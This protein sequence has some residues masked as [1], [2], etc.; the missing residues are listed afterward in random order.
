M[1]PRRS[2]V[3]CSLKHPVTYALAASL[4]AKWLYEAPYATNCQYIPLKTFRRGLFIHTKPYH[5]APSVT[6]YTSPLCVYQIYKIKEWSQVIK[7]YLLDGQVNRKVRVAAVI[8]EQLLLWEDQ[9]LPL[10]MIATLDRSNVSVTFLI[11]GFL[12]ECNCWCSSICLCNPKSRIPWSGT[13][14]QKT[15]LLPRIATTIQ[16]W[17]CS[18]IPLLVP[19]WALHLPCLLPSFWTLGPYASARLSLSS[20]KRRNPAKTEMHQRDYMI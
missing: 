4:P 13:M 2:C 8:F 7:H 20:V 10:Y 9:L 18:L 6:S 17:L 11:F 12:L 14:H 3:R 19:F 15:R 1:S 5:P 16:C